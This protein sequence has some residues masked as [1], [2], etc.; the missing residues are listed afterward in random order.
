MVD[1]ANLKI[2]C[3]E[4]GKI[5]AANKGVFGFD[6]RRNFMAHKPKNRRRN[7]PSKKRRLK[8]K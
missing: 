7:R 4:K 6:T 3:I 8:K 2:I 5:V 1:V